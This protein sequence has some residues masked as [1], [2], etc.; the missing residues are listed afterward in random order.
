MAFRRQALALPE[1]LRGSGAQAHFEVAT[2]LWARKRRCRLVYDPSVVI[3]HYR[4]PRFD[5]D[6][7]ERPERNAIRTARSTWLQRWSQSS[8]SATGAE[9]PSGW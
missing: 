9:P 2:C 5:A 1:S 6:R 4:A 3:D 8:P 7:R